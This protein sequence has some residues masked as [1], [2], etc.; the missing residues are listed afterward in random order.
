MGYS[1]FGDLF[2]RIIQLVATAPFES[3]VTSYSGDL[4]VIERL[5]VVSGVNAAVSGWATGCGVGVEGAVFVFADVF[6]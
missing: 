3:S 2:L 1:L 4:I 5:G 6:A